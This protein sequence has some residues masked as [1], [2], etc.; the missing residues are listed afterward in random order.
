MKLFW[1]QV[2]CTGHQ[3][4]RCS[5]SKLSSGFVSRRPDRSPVTGCK[6]VQTPGMRRVICTIPIYIQ[7]TMSDPRTE[8]CFHPFK[9]PCLIFH[10]RAGHRVK[11]HTPEV[12]GARFIGNRFAHRSPFV[13]FHK[14][15]DFN[16]SHAWSASLLNWDRKREYT[17][18]YTKFLKTIF[19]F[20]HDIPI[21]SATFWCRVE[22][23]RICPSKA[24]AMFTE[25]CS[26]LLLQIQRY[27]LRLF[28]AETIRAL[29]LFWR[30]HLVQ[31]HLG[32]N[33][34]SNFCF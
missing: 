2:S 14:Y 11:V 18:E 29:F 17:K 28:C 32:N 13:A 15:L 25:H 21:C 27:H 26:A 1:N 24:S 19:F 4:G 12:R 8:V 23:S 33:M 30:V 5:G 16:S 20:L 10:E 7:Y 6:Y 9:H 22:D 34:L 31:H 3:T